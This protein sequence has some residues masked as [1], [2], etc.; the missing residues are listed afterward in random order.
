MSHPMPSSASSGGISSNI[1]NPV[2]LNGEMA[3]HIVDDERPLIGGKTVHIVDDDGA[4]RRVQA[5][6]LRELC[7]DVR[8]WPDG[9]SFLK[10]AP[11][12][13]PCC[14]MLDVGLPGM[15]GLAVHEEMIRMGLRWPVVFVSG[16]A[17]TER[18]VQAMRGGAVH[19]L[20]KPIRLADLESAL[21][22]AFFVL[23]AQKG[24][25]P[26][27]A[28]M[29]LSKLT[30]REREVLEGLVEGLPNKSI[31][32]DLGVSHRTVEAHRANIMAKLE[33]SNLAQL[34]RLVI[35]AEMEAAPP[36]G[37]DFLIR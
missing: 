29:R 17:D 14:I 3:F 19:F 27:A 9:K 13:G 8:T 33:V 34:V 21:S 26:C 31:A 12:F 6:L 1:I 25:C 20:E 37:S 36:K 7:Y 10:A 15:D 22:N 30:S 23:E 5:S 28:R 18:V 35:E 11:G 24:E 4:C 2:S 32:Y 16:A